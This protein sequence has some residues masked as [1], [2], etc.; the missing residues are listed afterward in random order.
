LHLDIRTDLLFGEVVRWEDFGAT[1]QTRV[2]L[3]ECGFRWV[4]MQDPE[5]NEFCVCEEP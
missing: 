3:E 5:G 1:R 2:G 4:F